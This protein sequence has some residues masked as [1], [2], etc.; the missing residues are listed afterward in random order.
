MS[1]LTKYTCFINEISQKLRI[2]TKLFG[3]ASGLKPLVQFNIPLKA[4]LITPP[5]YNQ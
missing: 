1:I 4:N 5:Y 3:F 2:P